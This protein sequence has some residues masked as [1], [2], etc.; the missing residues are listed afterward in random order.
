[1]NEEITK[2]II[3]KKNNFLED[4]EGENKFVNFLEELHQI[5]VL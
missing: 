5:L 2:L 4:K 3:E 1:V